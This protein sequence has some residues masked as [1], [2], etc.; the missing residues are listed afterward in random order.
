MRKL[1]IFLLLCGCN[2]EALNTCEQER[3]KLVKQNSLLAS[4][5]EEFSCPKKTCPPTEIVV[6]ASR[7]CV[8]SL[9]T[10]RQDL[11]SCEEVKTRVA[12]ELS[13]CLNL[14][15]ESEGVLRSCKYK[16]NSMGV[17]R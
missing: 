11:Q 13:R 7:K 10:Q 14:M 9:K 17:G 8:R 4:T 12:G 5:I 1:L 6:K 15:R 16:P 3:D 2:Q